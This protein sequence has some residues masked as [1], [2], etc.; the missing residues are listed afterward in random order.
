MAAALVCGMCRLRGGGSRVIVSAVAVTVT[1]CLWGVQGAPLIAAL[2]SVLSVLSGLP[3][4]EAW[5]GG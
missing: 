1:V 4:N 3:A 5:V 2:W